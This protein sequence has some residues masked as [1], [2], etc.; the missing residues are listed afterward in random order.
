MR[1]SPS[2]DDDEIR[3][4]A[5]EHPFVKQTGDFGGETVSTPKSLASAMAVR[6]LVSSLPGAIGFLRL[7]DIN[8]SVKVVKLDGAGPGEPAYKL[9]AGN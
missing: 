2:G 3:N 1:S 6:Q 9:K 5:I 8:D 7:S 4:L